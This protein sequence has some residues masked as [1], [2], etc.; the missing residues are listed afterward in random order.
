MPNICS[1]SKYAKKKQVVYGADNH[2]VKHLYYI[3][4]RKF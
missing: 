4:N 3:D 2:T 1:K